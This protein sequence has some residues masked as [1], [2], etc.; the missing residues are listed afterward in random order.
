MKTKLVLILVLGLSFLHRQELY[1]QSFESYEKHQYIKNNDTLPYRLLLPEGYQKAKKYPLVIFLHGAGERGNDN[2]KQLTHGGALFVSAENRQKYPAI[3]VF[4][5]CSQKSYWSNVKIAGSGTNRVFEFTNGGT[6]TFPMQL[7]LELMRD[8]DTRYGIKKQ[9]V[10]VMGLSM[11]G[12]GTFE[13]VNRMPETFAAAIPICGGANTATAAN[14]KGT[15]WWVFHGGKDDVVLPRY[16]EEMVAAMKKNKVN[17]KFTLFPDA[18][19]NSWDA[20]FA[21]PGLL[22]WLFSQSRSR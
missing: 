8:L 13:L 20:T 15:K 11:G 19:H 14:L 3:V 16:S 17:V 7:L 12:M 1:A 5:Q 2:E 6:P 21:Q 9:Q 22:K 4:P 10:Y 18:N